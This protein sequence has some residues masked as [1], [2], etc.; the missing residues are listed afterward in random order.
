MIAK[1]KRI[2]V[3]S[4]KSFGNLLLLEQHDWDAEGRY[5][6][7]LHEKNSTYDYILLIRIKPFCEDI[8]KGNRWLYSDSIDKSKLWEQL[9]KIT[10]SYDY[11]GYITREHLIQI[12]CERYV[13]PKGA[14]LNGSTK[15]DAD[16]YYVQAGDMLDV[17]ELISELQ[18]VDVAS[19]A[20][21]N[22]PAKSKKKW[23]SFLYKLFRRRTNK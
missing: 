15:I 14:F 12:I 3:K 10:W 9:E 23:Y 6:P 8:L 17:A 5:I 19:N 22:Q 21:E 16:N 1:N 2:A 13:L 7:N 18:A 4:T 20:P 11:A